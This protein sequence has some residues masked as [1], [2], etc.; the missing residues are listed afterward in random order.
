M[1]VQLMSVT[2]KCSTYLLPS[3]F[4]NFV[5]IKESGGGG[6]KKERKKECIK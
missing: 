6:D 3:F 2:K 4:I 5:V 1:I